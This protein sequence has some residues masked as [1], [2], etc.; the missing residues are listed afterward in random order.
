LRVQSVIPAWSV[1][2]VAATGT[3][4]GTTPTTE[5]LI[6][7]AAV[8]A[9]AGEGGLWECF[10]GIADP[11]DRR[12]VRHSVPTILGLCT[13]AA[14][15]GQVLL[16]DITA[17]IAAAGQEV[18]AAFG[19]RRDAQGR[20]TPPHP[21]TVERLL[22]L[23]EAQQ[24]ADGVG[25]WLAARA[26]VG[27]VGA[28]TGGPGWLPAIAVDGKAV[29]GAV[30]RGGDTDGRVP[31]LLAAATHGESV[32]IA[33][34]LI[35]AKTNEVPE[36][37]PLLRGLAQQLAGVGGVGG[38]VFTMDAAHTVRAH[39]K[40]ITAE[41]FAHYVMIVKQNTPTLYDEI[42][43]LDW[44]N[45]PIAHQSRHRTRPAGQAHHPRPRRPRGPR[46]PRC[47]AGVPHRA[48]HHPHRP[49]TPQRQPPLQEGAGQIRGRC[50]RRDQPVGPRGHPRTPG[51]LR[52]RTVDDRKQ[53]PLG[54]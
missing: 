40:L 1:A 32:V 49:Q 10:A 27:P 44:A 6:E 4:P 22:S 14:A 50:P 24:L 42:D 25:G 48:L 46:V 28:L 17:W 38:C 16:A 47:R 11:R 53:D 37:A 36:F 45:A 9:A 54:A 30:G 18:L 43:A 21:D 7:R 8:L 3:T 13:A 2:P 35:G 12:G 34:R 31:Y 41:L 20:H 19:C 39:A 52:P 23:L 29:R 51:R 5:V 33:E 26:G 15:A